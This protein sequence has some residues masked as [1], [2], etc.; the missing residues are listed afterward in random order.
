MLSHVASMLRPGGWRAILASMFVH[1]VIWH[2]ES[3]NGGRL[4]D[5][6]DRRP[7]N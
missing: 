1:V 4:T 5:I 2:G 7:A 3:A 6:G